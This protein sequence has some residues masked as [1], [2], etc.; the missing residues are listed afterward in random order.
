MRPPSDFRRWPW[1]AV[2]GDCVPWIGAGDP[3]PSPREQ[4]AKVGTGLRAAIDEADR[5]SAI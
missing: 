5:V 3:V 2:T 1:Y 4:E